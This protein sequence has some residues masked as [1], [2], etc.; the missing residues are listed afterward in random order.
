VGSHLRPGRSR[1]AW[2]LIRYVLAWALVVTAV[3]GLFW[4]LQEVL[5]DLV[6]SDSTTTTT[7][8]VAA[9]TTSTEPTT[10]TTSTPVT[11][12][13]VTPRPT[14]T[15]TTT[16]AARPPEE[17]AVTVLNST[18]RVGLAAEVA[19]DLAALGYVVGQPGNAT[20]QRAVTTILHAEG[21]GIEAIELKETAFEDEATV[22]VDDEG[23]TD[24]ETN[25]V[26]ILGDSYP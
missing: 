16:P 10:T 2:E 4:L 14:T 12:T 23:R 15:T 19:A 8:P 17:L 21:F 3:V 20:P 5:P 6:A 22:G 26:V 25:I 13:T 7:A 1:F 18:P 11:T 9:S 24:D